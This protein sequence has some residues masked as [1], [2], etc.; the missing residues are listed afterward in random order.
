MGEQIR[1]DRQDTAVPVN[2]TVN[3]NGGVAGL[4]AIARVRLGESTTQYLDFDDFT[5]KGA[6]WVDIDADLTD[7]GGGFYVLS[8][9]LDVSA[10]TN[11]PA[12]QE[13]LVVEYEVSGAEAGVAQ[14][15]IYVERDVEAGFTPLETHRLTASVMAGRVSGGPANPIFRDLTNTANRVAMT[16]DTNGNRTSVIL[17]P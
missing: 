3:R 6:G 5:F 1:A 11:L 12:A 16:A 17:T 2:L 8:G 15:L 7:I 4:T 10:I 9:G 13:I 14:D